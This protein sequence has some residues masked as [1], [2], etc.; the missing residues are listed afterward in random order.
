MQHDDTRKRAESDAKAAPDEGRRKLL[1][2]GKL[3]LP[4]VVTLQV[5]YSA[6]ASAAELGQGRD[7]LDPHARDRKFW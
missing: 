7:T 4:A 3:A 6:W 1:K 2:R 5:S